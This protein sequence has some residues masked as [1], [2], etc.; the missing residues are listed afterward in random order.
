VAVRSGEDIERVNLFA[1]GMVT[2]V[3]KRRMGR[4]WLEFRELWDGHFAILERRNT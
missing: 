3:I 1:K 2:I 4:A